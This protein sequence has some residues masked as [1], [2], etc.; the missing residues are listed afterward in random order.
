MTS[1]KGIPESEWRRV[2][3][4]VRRLYVDPDMTL[5]SLMAYMLEHHAFSA[6]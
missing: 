5:Q 4:V 6:T 1:T 2:E 3:S